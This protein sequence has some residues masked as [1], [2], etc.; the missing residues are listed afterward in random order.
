M[1]SGNMIAPQRIQIQTQ[2]GCN[3]RCVFC[4]NEQFIHAHLPTGKM[5]EELFRSIIDQL[6]PLKPHRIMPYLQNEPLLDERLP[7]LIAYIYEKMPGVTTLVVSNGTKLTNEMGER[8]IKSG[9]K[10]LKISLQ[11]L[12]DNTNKELMGYPATPVVENIINFS[13]LLKR[14]HSAMDFRVSAIVTSKNE[15]E[16]G[17]M[18]KFWGKHKIRL[19]LSA[20]ENRGGNIANVLSISNTP[21]MQQRRGCIRPTRDMCILFN[22]EVVLCCV[23]WL[24]TTI[25]G[26]LNK[27]SVTE[28][29]NTPRIQM[30]REGLNMEDC[31]HLPEICRN[32]SEAVETF[33]KTP[34]WWKQLKNSFKQV[35]QSLSQ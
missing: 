25:L 18:K 21:Q 17:G 30:I 13:N 6:V 1:S 22:G 15:A 26:D 29:W 27:K 28:I 10:R 34:S 33:R 7:E 8:L 5:S 16:I 31:C 20:L 24:R 3:G 12:N 35:F 19:V 23:D 14:Y 4:P 2:T 9:L 11:S 32:C